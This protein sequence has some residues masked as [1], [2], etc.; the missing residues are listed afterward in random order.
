MG[1]HGGDQHLLGHHQEFSRNAPH[2]GTG[3]FHQIGYF[4]QQRLIR[5]QVPACCFGQ[6]VGVPPDNFL[7]PLLVNNH[8]VPFALFHVVGKIPHR[9]TAVGHETVSTGNVAALDRPEGKGDHTTVEQRHNPVDRTGKADIQV[10]PAHGLLEGNGS[11][12]PGEQFRQQF[13]GWSA[14]FFLVTARYSP[15]SVRSPAK[16]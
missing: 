6:A 15:L 14:G 9:K 13:M 10:S 7:A 5:Q 16:R 11:Q 4:I 12:Q 2:K 3:V 1:A 8:K